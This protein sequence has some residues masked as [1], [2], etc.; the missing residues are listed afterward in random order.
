MAT[1]YTGPL[2]NK[3]KSAGD[4]EWYSK[5][6]IGQEIDYFIYW[7][8]FLFDQDYA[9]ADWTITTTEAG[10]GNASEALA[11]D[12]KGGALLITNDDADNDSDELQQKQETWSLTSG[13]RCWYATRMKVSDATQSDFF[14]G[15]AITDTTIIDGTTDLVGFRK[16]DGDANIDVVT[17]KDSTETETDSGQDAADDTYV[18]LG[19][20]YDGVSKVEFYIDDAKVATHTTNLPDNENLCITIALQNGEAAAKTMT[21]DYIYVCQER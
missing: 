1:H 11:T 9:A 10:A 6:P 17:E 8:D 7:N 3:D 15:L 14:V 21:V 16:D 20:Y 13:K 5:L 19:F 4:R 12:E 2:L 18:K